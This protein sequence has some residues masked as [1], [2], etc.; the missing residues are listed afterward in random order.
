M[1]EVAHTSI[2]LF[3]GKF[4][5]TWK[6]TETAQNRLLKIIFLRAIILHKTEFAILTVLPCVTT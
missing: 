6:I 3:L 1:F 5:F 4:T 2:G